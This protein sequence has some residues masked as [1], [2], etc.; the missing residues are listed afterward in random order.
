VRDHRPRGGHVSG[1]PAFP[2]IA[3]CLTR[4][5]AEHVPRGAPAWLTAACGL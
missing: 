1:S 4:N 2:A 3:G 5:R